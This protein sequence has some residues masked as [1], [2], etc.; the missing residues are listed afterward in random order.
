ARG[1]ATAVGAAG[2][3]ALPG[4][5]ADDEGAAEESTE[6]GSVGLRR[7]SVAPSPP[8]PVPELKKPEPVPPAVEDKSTLK[9]AQA[10]QTSDGD[11]VRATGSMAVA[12]LLS[13]ITGFIRNVLIGSSL[14]AAIASAFTT[15]NQLPNLITEIVLGAV[16]TSLVVPVLVRAEKEDA[17]HGEAF[18]RRLFTLAVTLLGAI[19][20]L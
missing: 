9:S 14:G 8:A 3:V 6:D 1:S 18:V 17:D 5:R 19:T 10:T 20:L 2:V 16:L 4:E 12:T 11:V 7:R 13:R 15:A